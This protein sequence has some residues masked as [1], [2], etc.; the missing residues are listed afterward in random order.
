MKNVLLPI[1]AVGALLLAGASVVRHL[2]QR[3][4]TDAPS[5][6]PESQFSERVAAVGLIEASTENI[7]VGTHLAGIVQRV[8]VSAGQHVNVGDPLF[9]ID[10]RHLRAQLDLQRAALAV[11]VAELADL[12]NQL[13]RA[14]TLS[15]QKVISLD[16]L[17][18]RRFGVRTLRARVAQAD[19]AAKASET[20]IARS[21]VAAPIEGEVLKL[22]A[23]PG[24]FAAAGATPEP[25]L[26]L[27]CLVPLHLRVD[28]DEQDAW[29][30]EAR[31]KA[32]AAVRGNPSQQTTLEFVRFE[33]YVLPKR[34][35]TG[36]SAERVDTRV[37]QV[38]YR[39]QPDGLPIHVGQQMDVFIEAA[40][41]AGFIS[42][43]GVPNQ[44]AR[45]SYD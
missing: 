44:T 42:K 2:P 13:G 10:N 26:L 39:F 12:E 18:R 28:V 37:L 22:N 45:S 7:A 16:E 25:L 4:L 3:E 17:D 15:R 43:K 23:R 27:G 30:V 14:E 1:V 32:V 11:A 38:I 19:A 6:P 36:G 9:E 31:A 20:E 35:L 5:P 21:R 40:P 34:S 41:I 8:F 33:P 24:E 29:R